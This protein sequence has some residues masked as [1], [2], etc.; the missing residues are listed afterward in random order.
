MCI[1][2]V[3]YSNLIDRKKLENCYKANPDSMGLMFSEFK[4]IIIHKE[5][6]DF[7]SF[8][9]YYSNVRA[10]IN[11]PI[12]LHFRITTSGLIDLENCHPFR[13]NDNLAFC[14]NGIITQTEYKKSMFSDTWHFNEDILKKLPANFLSNPGIVSLIN[15]FIGFSKLA[16][17]DTDNNVTI[18]GEH[19]GEKDDGNWYS[20]TGYKT[21]TWTYFV[22]YKGFTKSVANTVINDLS[23]KNKKAKNDKYDWKRDFCYN[24]GFVLTTVQ[25]KHFNI[26][27]QCAK[28]YEMDINKE[29]AEEM[30]EE[31][32]ASDYQY[33]FDYNK[34]NFLGE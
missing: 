18:I 13:I 4:K 34:D 23:K 33:T 9:T 31:I 16:F 12:V 6:K 24:C 25:E 2:A 26:C 1:I 28:M 21:P 11:T 29:Y 22:P 30:G 15:D 14:H 10:R 8:Y 3:N 20:N 5:I 17:L 19:R 32:K 27:T 7:D